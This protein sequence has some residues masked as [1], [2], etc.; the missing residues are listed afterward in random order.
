MLH[1]HQQTV[2]P[3]HGIGFSEPLV[4]FG[5]RH[6]LR[7]ENQQH[8]QELWVTDGTAAG[9]HIVID[10]LP[11]PG[12]SNPKELLAAGGWLYFTANTPA[13]GRELFRTDGTASGT[14]LVADLAPGPASSNPLHLVELQG[15]IYFQAETSTTGTELYRS[16]GTPSG[17]TLVADIAVGAASSSPT[18][19]EALPSAGLVLFSADVGGLGREPWLSDGTTAGTSILGSSVPGLDG[20]A[21]EHLV[22]L[23]SQILFPLDDGIHG[24]E[25]WGTDG[26]PSG[27]GLVADIDPSSATESLDVQDLTPVGGR[28]LYFSGQGQPWCWDPVKGLTSLGDLTPSS[29]SSIPHIF[30]GAWLA[31]KWVVVFMA[32]SSGSF[33]PYVTDGTPEGTQLLKAIDGPGSDE[34]FVPAF[35]KLFFR[36]GDGEGGLWLTNGTPAGTWAIPGAGSGPTDMTLLGDRLLYAAT[37]WLGRELWSTKGS[38]ATTSKVIDLHAGQSANPRHL[39]RVG[40]QVAFFT[41]PPTEWDHALWRTD[42]TA[43]GTHWVATVSA[44][45]QPRLVQVHD[46]VLYFVGNGGIWR[47]DMTP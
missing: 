22:P 16:D 35:G 33:H 46:D 45:S 21:P 1:D 38:A 17:T 19:L 37:D 10:I 5:G 18:G 32:K 27:T 15:T 24:M 13:F 8:G 41:A 14:Q 4:A 30:V 42:G 6:Y 47:S 34:T 44:A 39:R 23:Q 20:M 7:A 2:V 26:T 9:T 40:D 12:D 36:G 28:S 25:L 3:A 11:G 31:G 43:A 29:A